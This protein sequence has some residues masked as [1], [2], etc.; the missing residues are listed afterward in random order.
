MEFSFLILNLKFQFYILNIN[1]IEENKILVEIII[2]GTI[3]WFG[4][5]CNRI[6][7]N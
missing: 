6:D 5:H 4:E 7:T 3:G 2:N 1:K